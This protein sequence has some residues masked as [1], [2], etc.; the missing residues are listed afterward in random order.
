MSDP[1]LTEW[2]MSILTMLNEAPTTIFDTH[3]QLGQSC[4]YYYRP[5]DPS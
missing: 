2:W 5:A 3:E 1:R 4:L